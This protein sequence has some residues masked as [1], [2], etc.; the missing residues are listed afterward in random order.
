VLPTVSAAQISSG[1]SPNVGVRPLGGYG[2]QTVTAASLSIR[3]SPGGATIGNLIYGDQFYTSTIS[4]SWC[5]G[6]G[7]YQNGPGFTYYKTGWV[8]CDYLKKNT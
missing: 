5:Y 3:S 2:W 7:Y 6:D 1:I 4:G 8:L